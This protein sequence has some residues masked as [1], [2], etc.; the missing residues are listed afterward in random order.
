MKKVYVIIDEDIW[1]DQ[2]GE[3]QGYDSDVIHVCSSG[4]IAINYVNEYIKDFIYD[5]KENEEKENPED[6]YTY[7]DR[8][9]TLDDL[10]REDFI[11]YYRRHGPDFTLKYCCN[12]KIKEMEVF[13]D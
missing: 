8:E 1:F 11:F 7:I 6:K 2:L 13:E 4:D 5:V 10:N 9:L 12:I 3:I